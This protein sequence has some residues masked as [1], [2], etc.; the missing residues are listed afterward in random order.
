M[1]TYP[2]LPWPRIS[3]YLLEVGSAR[4]LEEFGIRALSG[5]A[6]LVPFD[7]NGFYG[8]IN[9]TGGIYP[10]ATVT[11]ASKWFGLFNNYYCKIQPNLPASKTMITDWRCWRHTE[12]VTDFIDPQGIGFSAAITYLE[13]N[14]SLMG[15]FTLHRSKTSTCF[16]EQERQ[17]LEVIQ[18]HLSNFHAIN[19]LFA[20]GGIQPL[21]DAAAIASDYRCLTK[22]EAEIAALIC[23]R[24]QTP[25]IASHLLISPATVYR[26]V[27]NIFAKLNV[28]NRDELLEKL[29]SD[30]SGRKKPN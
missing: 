2:G 27:A 20:A 6:E 24:F 14:D 9:P 25:M 11:E 7:V 28:F 21:P 15:G 1:I 30:Y 5:L 10:R 23:R 12:Y 18:P 22:R 16:S 3:D 17:I 13:A 19:T 29:L 4:N 8:V 26:H